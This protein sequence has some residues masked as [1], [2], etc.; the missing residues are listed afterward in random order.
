[1]TISGSFRGGIQVANTLYGAWTDELYTLTSDG[2]RTLFGT[3]SGTDQIF[4]AANNA[5]TP[6]VAIVCDAGPFLIS[7]ASIIAYPDADVNSPSCLCV[8]EGYFMFGYGDG[9]IQ[10]SDLNSTNLNTLNTASS[11]TNPDGVDNLISYQGQLFVMGSKTI[12]VWGDPVN[13]SGFPLTRVG[14]NIVPGIITPMAVAGWQPEFGNNFIY[15]GSDASVRQLNGYTPTK[16]SPPELDELIASV[17]FKNQINCLCYVSRGHAFW[18]INGPDFSWV[19][20]CN[21][22]KWHERQSY[23]SN[24]SV[25]YSYVPAFDKWLVGST[26]STDLLEI[27]FATRTEAGAALTAQM[28]SQNVLDF[29]NR[30]RVARADFDFTVGV[31]DVT[32]TDPI[33][34]DPTVLIEWS[35]DG[36][37]TWSTPWWRKLG[38][39]DVT[40]QRVTVLNTGLCGPMGRRWRVSVSDPVHFGFLGASMDAE[41]RQK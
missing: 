13:T 20:D 8:H 35:N 5:A 23:N 31:G 2:E 6:N 16:I 38:R 19:Y 15:V 40:D 18:Q 30:M 10:A 41:I 21:T 24:K 22:Q 39:E 17:V 27:D 11:E 37:Q 26:D 12:E 9:T 3:L 34:T 29:P 1:M 7:G 32:G 36:G 25:L 28:E 4:M 33:E 14:Y